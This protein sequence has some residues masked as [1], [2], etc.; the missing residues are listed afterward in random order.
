SPG[1][2]IVQVSDAC[3]ARCPQCELRA[4]NSFKRSRIPIDRLKRI[5]DS[6]AEKGIQSLSF[7]GG[8]P[9]LLGDELFDIIR[10]AGQAG[11]RYTR[12]GTNAFFLRG[13]DQPDWEDKVRRIAE[14]LADTP[15]YTFWISIDSAD[16]GVHEEM[17]GLPGAI[18]GIERALPI[19]HEYG[20]YPA[21]NLG[22]N[23]N[24]GGRWPTERRQ[25][26]R[27]ARPEAFLDAFRRSFARFYRTVVDMGFTMCNACYPM[28]IQGSESQMLV[29]VYG[30]SAENFL[31]K[32]AREEK[33]LLFRAMRE[34][35]PRFA[36]RL[37]IFTPLTSLYALERHYSGKPGNSYACRGGI[38][39]FFVDAQ[40]G[41]TYPCGF[42]GC[43]DLGPFEALD[44]SKLE[45]TPWCRECDWECYR[46][47]SELLGPV[48]E[49]FRH[50][51]RLA[52][53]FLR[54]PRFFSLWLRDVQYYRAAEFF[55][56]RRAADYEALKPF[57]GRGTPQ[58][59][60]S[61]DLLNAVYVKPVQ[62]TAD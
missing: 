17:R 25:A 11:I 54:D 27:L 3:N 21:A 37:R 13:A 7:T 56:G 58:D 14:K 28:S 50:P 42:R 33:A 22:V 59:P 41:H 6:A 26:A 9:F 46:D 15:L 35:I 34:T 30:A 55:N 38:D 57:L 49:L 40:K 5:I 48:T 51:L 16:A 52:G 32:F 23:R 29:M 39:Y 10:Y 36:D 53:R 60:R 8:E 1:Q 61:Q 12:T 19:F 43:E 31:V 18:K 24:T 2:L 44:S 47:P 4:D 20:V 62:A 45:K